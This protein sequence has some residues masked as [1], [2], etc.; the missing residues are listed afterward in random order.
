MAHTHATDALNICIGGGLLKKRGCEGVVVAV[1][2]TRSR[3]LFE[4]MQ[5]V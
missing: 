4:P 3:R 1:F 5:K 2:T